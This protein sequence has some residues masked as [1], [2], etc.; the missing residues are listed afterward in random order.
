MELDQIV[1]LALKKNKAAEQQL[2]NTMAPRLMALCRRYS[3]DDHMAKDYF[4]EAFIKA[5][6][7]LSK[8]DSN[9]G[10]FESWFFRVSTNVILEDKRKKKKIRFTEIDQSA[11]IPFEEDD[12]DRIR[13]EDLM[14]AI[15]KLPNG[16]RDILNLYIFEKWPHKDIAAMMGINEATSRSQFARAKKMLKR[17]LIQTIPNIYEKQLV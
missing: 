5:F 16:Y 1:I 14:A 2:F 15:R 17:I 8:Y 7:N 9:K 13:D 10:K 4:Q 3:D 6:E 12:L 11:E